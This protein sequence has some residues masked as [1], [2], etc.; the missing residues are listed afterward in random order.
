MA[1]QNDAIEAAEEMMIEAWQLLMRLP[2]R[3]KGWLKSG[4]RSCLPAPIQERREWYIDPELAEKLGMEVEEPDA[5]PRQQLGRREMALIE[6][7]FLNPHCLAEA[8]LEP[9][10]SLFAMVISIKAGRQA[11]GFRW[12]D[13]W[14]RYGG[15]GKQVTSDALR[16]RYEASLGR[17]AVRW[18][19]V[20]G[21]CG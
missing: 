16:A 12:S 1:R 11:G 14:V 15:K 2:D 9:H 5:R 17:V 13:V 3:E 21:K 6:R 7:A 4:S 19:V 20:A 10:R 18:A 8:V